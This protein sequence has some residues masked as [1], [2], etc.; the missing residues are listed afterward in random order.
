MKRMYK[1]IG[2]VI[3]LGI[4]VSYIG[5][6]DEILTHSQD[7]IVTIH[8][9]IG[10]P[11]GNM[12]DFDKVS[13]AVNERTREALGMELHLDFYDLNEAGLLEYLSEEQNV[14]LLLVPELQEQVQK[15]IL[16]P[17]DELLR[18]EGQ[19]IYDVIAPA[20]MELGKVNGRQYG[21]VLNRDMA[22]AYGVSM[23]KDLIEK[24][25]IDLEEIQ[26]WEDV[27]NVL[28]IVTEGE[29][30]YGIA[31]DTLMPFDSL[32]NSLGVLMSDEKEMKVVNYYETE[33]FYNWMKRIR[34]WKEKGYLYTKETVRYKSMSDRPFLYE[35]LRE[36][37]LFSY[38]VKYK[39]GINAQESKSAGRELVSVMIEDPI[40]TT[41]SSASSQYGIYSGSQHPEEAMEML[42]FL[43]TDEK[44]TNL[45]C[46]GLEGEHYQ[47]NE[48]GTIS[49][50]DGKDESEIGYN[51]NLNWLLPNPYLA[52]VWEGDDLNLE[53]ELHLFNETAVKSPALGFAFDDSD[54]RLECEVTSGIVDMYLSGFLCGAFDVDE[55]L[56]KMIKELK[57]SGIDLIIEEKQRQLNKWKEQKKKRIKQSYQYN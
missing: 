55:I 56:P 37:Q 44:I 19:D 47:K 9:A 1:I 42:N 10:K 49:Y 30:I 41:D 13:E 7:D 52:Y 38:I 22:S 50:P 15:N 20:Y 26:T 40:M 5:H 16:L 6:S 54:V 46:W 45:L 34:S 36:G 31:A 2:A 53:E 8:M 4:G 23:R 29:E 32:G 48:D 43:Y 51:F 21:I 35:L 18:E 14:D 17:L 25:D 27:E 28:E 24:Y 33:E 12:E 57:E 11:T 39:P 3:L